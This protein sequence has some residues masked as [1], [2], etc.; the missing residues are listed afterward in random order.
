MNKRTYALESTYDGDHVLLGCDATALM[1]AASQ[2]D[3][4]VVSTLIEAHGAVHVTTTDDANALWFAFASQRRSVAV[5][6]L[7]LE[8]GA[9]A[10]TRVNGVPLIVEVV[11]ACDEQVLDLLIDRDADVNVT[12]EREPPLM[13]A[14]RAGARALAEKLISKGALLNTEWNTST[15]LRDCIR[16]DPFDES[17]LTLLIE[18]GADVNHTREDVAETST[19][20]GAAVEPT[21]LLLAVARDRSV[22]VDLLLTNHADVNL[23]PTLATWPE[24]YTPLMLSMKA[25]TSSKTTM[26]RLYAAK[27]NADAT[28][29]NNWTALHIAA[30]KHYG[31]V[32]RL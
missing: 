11:A 2:G 24:R 15:A 3:E 10:T 13:T 22:A 30:H 28:G 26:D 17:M 5:I 4:A 12:S 23:S 29:M 21:P 8:N 27:P 32:H 19:F 31:L 20:F 9:D 7:L 25:M 14:V 16:H 6:E 18:H 1:I